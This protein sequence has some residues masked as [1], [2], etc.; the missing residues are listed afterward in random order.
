MP[1]ADN[2]QQLEEKFPPEIDRLL[3]KEYRHFRRLGLICRVIGHR[4][5]SWP[6]GGG[7]YDIGCGRCMEVVG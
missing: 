5:E 6:T 4:E 3:R 1:D 7:D 2:Q